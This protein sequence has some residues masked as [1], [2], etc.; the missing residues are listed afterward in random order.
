M[1]NLFIVKKGDNT[2]PSIRQ[3]DG[4]DPHVVRSVE[5]MEQE[6]ERTPSANG[7]ALLGAIYGMIG[8]PGKG[9]ETVKQALERWP[10]HVRLLVTAARL[11]NAG[12]QPEIAERYIERAVALD[13]TAETLAQQ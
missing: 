1:H 9:L 2:M 5:L 6:L 13:P 8:A 10:D 12:G 11:A 3:L 7:L 4:C